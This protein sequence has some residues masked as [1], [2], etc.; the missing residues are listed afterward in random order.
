MN[1]SSESKGENS[2]RGA[3]VGLRTATAGPPS[4][5]WILVDFDPQWGVYEPRGLKDDDNLYLI[6]TNC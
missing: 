1:M 5:L 6:K 3:Y 4:A 2:W